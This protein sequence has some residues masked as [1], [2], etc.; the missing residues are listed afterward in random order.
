MKL[1]LAACA[2]LP[3]IVSAE[4]GWNFLVMGDWGGSEIAPYTTPAEVITAQGMGVVA[5]AES[6]SYCVAL[7]DNFYTHGVHSTTDQRFNS[8]FEDVFTSDH[9]RGDDYFRVLLGNH[10]HLGDPTAQVNYSS[11]SD[12]W[13]MDDLY[14]S[15]SE[16][17]TTGKKLDTIFIDTV[18]WAGEAHHVTADG[19]VHSVHGNELPGPADPVAA[20]AQFEWLENKLKSSTADYIIVAGHY[21]V[22]SICEHGSTQTMM[23]IIPLLEK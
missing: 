12:R 7:G 20:D 1:L 3:A 19:E 8:T 21:P 18:I 14:W 13:R 10:D 17:T 15:F 5:K 4:P 23:N 16:T 11:I 9:L 6:S 22:W 2:A